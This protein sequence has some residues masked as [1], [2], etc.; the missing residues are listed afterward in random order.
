MT[1]RLP[2]SPA[3]ARNREPLLT[4]LRRWLPETGVV[5]EVASGLGE[6]AVWFAQALPGITWQP[7]DRDLEANTVLAARVAAAGVTNLR[8]PLTLDASKPETWPLDRADAMVCINMVHISPWAATEGLMA[9]AAR[10][11]PPGA[12]LCLY[13][14]YREAGVPTAE[15]NL[16]FDADLKRRDPDWGL[17]DLEAVQALAAREDLIF[18]ERVAMPANNLCLLFR[19]A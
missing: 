1:S 12:P 19:R 3:S 4:V 16:A 14:P 11:L 15:S 9:G 8:P 17:R 7:T 18:T 10:L 2:G 13:G 6:H 5:V